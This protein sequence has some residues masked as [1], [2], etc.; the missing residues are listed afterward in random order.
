MVAQKD[1]YESPAVRAFAGELTAWRG[2]MSKVE[3]AETL[4]YTPQLIGQI[5]AGKNIPSKQFA[6]DLD[7]YFKTNGVFVRL[8]KLI[9][10]TRHLTAVPP[11]FPEFVERELVA[12]VMHVFDP[13]VVNGI[14]QTREYA[15]EVLKAG[16]NPEEIEHL[17]TKRLERQEILV[18]PKPLRIVAVMDEMALRRTIGGREVMKGQIEHLIERARQP[19]VTL[20][21]VAADKGSYAGLPGAFT[22][23]GFESGPD[24][25]YLE[26][27]LDGELIGNPATVRE[28]G[29]RYDLIRGAA[30]SDD[31][32]LKLLQSILESP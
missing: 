7:T 10:E 18:R 1:P 28:Y 31:E 15:Y 24:L 21:I 13:I 4:G 30:M 26:G 32:S 12:T 3:L 22:S 20:Q 8:W 27:H 5:E 19:N 11:G 23:M 17:V 25:V 14:L 16:R 29:L 6:E 9:T 2:A